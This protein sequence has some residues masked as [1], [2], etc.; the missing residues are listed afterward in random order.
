MKKKNEHYDIIIIGAGLVGL[1]MSLFLAKNKIKV[2]LIEKK[3]I[4]RK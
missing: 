3:S 2:S 4:K 1:I